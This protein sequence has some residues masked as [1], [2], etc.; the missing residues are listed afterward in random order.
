MQIEEWFDVHNKQHLA[1]WE[2]LSANGSW[3]VDF[4]PED[5]ELGQNWQINI[6]G[7]MANAWV[8]DKLSG[9]FVL[10]WR[11]KTGNF[12]NGTNGSL[13]KIVV[14]SV[15]W[16]SCPSDKNLRYKVTCTLPQIKKCESN[17]ATEEE[18]KD[19]L[20]SLANSWFEALK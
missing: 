17:F 3:T 18:G 12:T 20:Q 19:K 6:M 15:D 13:G 1:A 7:L 8:D 11:R 2:H 14:G 9:A 10:H 16:D 4:L 5:I